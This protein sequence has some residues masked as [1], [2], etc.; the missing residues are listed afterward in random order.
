MTPT[1]MQG[2]FKSSQKMLRNQLMYLQTIV[3][4][5]DFE[6][7][8]VNIK[9]RDLVKSYRYERAKN[10]AKI[11]HEEVKNSDMEFVSE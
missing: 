9:L 7:K 3:G 8:R 1:Q 6:Q 10:E 4:T 5:K 11:I 2:L